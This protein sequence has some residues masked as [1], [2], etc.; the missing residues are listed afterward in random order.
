M[1]V[2]VCVRERQGETVYIR[3]TKSHSEVSPWAMQMSDN[4]VSFAQNDK[5]CGQT[6]ENSEG[7]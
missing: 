3:K 7:W 1:C 5:L 6:E 2:F 4:F